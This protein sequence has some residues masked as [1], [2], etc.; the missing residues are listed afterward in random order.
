MSNRLLL[1]ST[2]ILATAGIISKFIGFFLRFPLMLLIGAKGFGLYN[3][4]Y[5]IY[6]SLLSISIAGIPTVIAKLVSERL[7]LDKHEEAHKI[8]I[9]AIKMLFI[10]GMI[11]SV[12]LFIGGNVLVGTIWPEDT[13]YSLMGL[14]LAPMF[15]GVLAVFRGYFQGMQNMVATSISQIIESLGRL[16]FGLGLAVLLVD[17]GVKYAAGGATFGATGGAFVGMIAIIVYYKLKRDN[18]VKG[19][20]DDLDYEMATNK[21]IVYTIAKLTV[22]ISIGALATT[23]MPM[24][25]SLMV[26][27]RLQVAGFSTDSAT[28]LFGNLGACNTI[29]NLPLGIIMAISMSLVPAIAHANASKR[30]LQVKSK[31]NQGLRMGIFIAI[32]AAVG[33]FSLAEPIL[34]L[35]FPE[36]ENGA[37]ILQVLS[38]ALIFITVNQILTSIIQA[39]GY[40]M[41]PVKNLFIGATIKIVLSFILLSIPNINILGAVIGTIV[42]YTISMILNLSFLRFKLNITIDVNNIVIKPIF[43]SLIMGAVVV[44]IRMYVGNSILWLGLDVLIGIIVY[45]VVSVATGCVKIEEIRKIL[46]RR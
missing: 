15:V 13:Y 27:S 39:L 44:L 6:A 18:I 35:I 1:K 42:A 10:V 38:I 17:Q 26:S 19:F 33:I 22:P 25:D 34:N 37:I 5:Q 46:K 45:A 4:P 3:Y 7:A 32:P 30:I 9:I 20:R 40:F 23:I 2:I 16:I 36:I 28:I 8:F 29:V 11:T 41:V 12:I 43:A 31:I 24:L 14:I 21:H